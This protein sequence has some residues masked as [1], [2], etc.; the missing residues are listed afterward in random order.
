MGLLMQACLHRIL[1]GALPGASVGLLV[2]YQSI[3]R[4]GVLPTGY[5]HGVP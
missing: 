2:V 5:F 4:G 3:T 1:G